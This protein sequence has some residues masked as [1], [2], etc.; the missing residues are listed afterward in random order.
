MSS[1]WSRCSSSIARI[2]GRSASKTLTAVT[3]PTAVTTWS[4]QA[5][6]EFLKLDTALFSC[7]KKSENLLKPP[8]S[9]EAS[10]Q[11][12]DPF[13]QRE[14]KYWS[15]SCSK[16]LSRLLLWT[17]Q[18][19]ALSAFHVQC[20]HCADWSGSADMFCNSIETI[21]LYTQWMLSRNGEYCATLKCSKIQSCT[22]FNV[23]HNSVLYCA[24]PINWGRVHMAAPW[25]HKR[26]GSLVSFLQFCYQ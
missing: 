15:K 9:E 2:S 13:N 1:W 3:D 6:F 5:S 16:K 24:A 4:A 10:H 21:L 8:A 12:V 26:G 17:E 20:V 7:H 11:L 14:E 23:V 18:C 22:M 19:N 25:P